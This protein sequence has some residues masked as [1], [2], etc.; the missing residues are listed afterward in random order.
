MSNITLDEMLPLLSREANARSG[1][2]LSIFVAVS[3]VFLVTG[4]LWQKKY[5]S[6]LQ[7]YVDDSNIVAP[8]IGTS[9]TVNR[10]DRQLDLLGIIHPRS[11]NRDMVDIKEQYDNRFVIVD[12]P[13]MTTSADAC[14]LSET[15][16]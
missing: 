12:G 16:G 10:S 15:C 13:A 4:F 3:L 7:L 1:T 14:I 6:L 5:T 9:S 8:I 11:K 2:L